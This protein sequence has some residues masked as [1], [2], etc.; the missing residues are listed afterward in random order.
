M[1]MVA[2]T[3]IFHYMLLLRPSSP[4]FFAI[5]AHTLLRLHLPELALVVAGEGVLA[6][7]RGEEQGGAA[8][9]EPYHAAQLQL[10]GARAL[11]HGGAGGG[12]VD[13]GRLR[14]VRRGRARPRRLP[15]A[16]QAHASKG[17]QASL[18]C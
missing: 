6:A 11:A 5:V 4:R 7:Q 15:P 10:A 2:G 12:E 14:E 13:V 16:C 1:Q 3:S 18:A 17:R 9:A 8:A